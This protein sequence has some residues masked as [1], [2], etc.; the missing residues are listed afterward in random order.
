MDVML[1]NYVL[2]VL[3]SAVLAS[4]EINVVRERE[5]WAVIGVFG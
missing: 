5:L 4:R 1:L 3:V 2:F